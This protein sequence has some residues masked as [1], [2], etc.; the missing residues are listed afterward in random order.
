[1]EFIQKQKSMSKSKH[2]DDNKQR[3]AKEREKK[4]G[5]IGLYKSDG[6]RF[7]LLT[8][9]KGVNIVSHIHGT[10][11]N[12]AG[13]SSFHVDNSQKYFGDERKMLRF[14]F[15]SAAPLKAATGEFAPLITLD[16]CRFRYGSN[17]LSWLL[18]DMTLGVSVGSRIG[19]LGKNGAGKSTLVKLLSGELSP[20]PKQGTLWRHPG[21]KIA[22]ITQHHIE[23]LGAH[24][25]ESPVEYFQDQHGT[26]A[27]SDHQIR[28]FL[29]GF[30]LVGNLA[31]QPI[32]SLSGGQKARL[33]FATVLYNPPHVLVLDEPTNHLDSQSLESLAKAITNF[34]GA[35]VIVS[36]HKGI[37]AQTCKEIWT[38]RNDG[39]VLA[40]TVESEAKVNQ[41]RR[42]NFD[43][44]YE[45]YK[46]GLRKEVRRGQTKKKQYHTK[47]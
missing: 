17:D 10:Y 8:E 22:H 42:S 45:N 35:V 15:P 24:L 16:E 14:Q 27:T 20:D 6:K 47:K 13:F 33:A 29:G 23:H 44:L 28:Q 37:L 18:Q 38:I 32:G 3:Q 36:H 30:G 4:I 25:N 2:R 5:R 34:E 12:A 26:T 9:R 11:T 31:L 43:V 1:M 46:E 41:Q 39:T 7:K 21:L 40:Q 19:I